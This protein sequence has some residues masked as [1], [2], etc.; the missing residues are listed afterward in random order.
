MKKKIKMMQRSLQATSINEGIHMDS[1]QRDNL[2]AHLQGSVAWPLWQHIGVKDHHGICVPLFSLHSKQSAGIGE[3][4]DLFPLITWCHEIGLDT[5]QLLPLNDTDSNSSPYGSLSAYALNPLHLGI[6]ALPNIESCQ[7]L[8][9]MLKDLQQLTAT[10][11]VDYKK[12]ITLRE[13]LLKDYFQEHSSP[14]LTSENYRQFC[15]RN[16]WLSGYALFRA[17]KS[18]SHWQSWTSW[19]EEIKH[20]SS[21]SFMELQK[22]YETNIHYHSFIQYLCFQQMQQIKQHADNLGIFIKGDIPILVDRESADLWLNPTLFKPEL[23]AGAPPDA[24]SEI[25]QNWQFP[26]YNWDEME[27]Q[28]YQWWKERLGVAAN[29][30]HIYRIDHIVGFF[31]IWAIPDGHLATEGH[32]IPENPQNA[33]EQGDKLMRMMLAASSMLPIGEDLGTIPPEVRIKLQEL[34]I[35]GTKVMR[36]E[37]NWNGDKRFIPPQDYQPLSITTVSTHDSSTLQEWWVQNSEE[38]REYCLSQGWEY[39]TP[40][41]P[42]YHF[43]ILYA[44]HHTAS[45]FHINLLQEYLALIPELVSAN[46]QDERINLPGII[47]DTNW[48]YRFRP[49]VEEL[50]DNAELAQLLRDL[51]K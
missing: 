30:Y 12:V 33:L 6:A 16:S 15:E 27:K 4:T 7:R 10:P 34:G 36:W 5:L 25:G 39:H 31:R 48:S 51:I 49:S 2:V 3:Y 41:S 45:L 46:P 18:Q 28:N 47:S 44:S 23:S 24:Y 26:L 29:F 42:E 50:I 9:A 22:K 1:T 40:L 20:C 11:R 35:C 17:I 32:F 8:L 19:P 37:R 43:A 14:I 21:A 38:A 13:Q